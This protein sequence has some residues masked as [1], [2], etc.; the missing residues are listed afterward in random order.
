MLLE[1]LSQLKGRGRESL[2][3]NTSYGYDY[4]HA[5]CNPNKNSRSLIEIDRWNKLR[6]RLNLRATQMQVL[7][8]PLGPLL[9]P[10]ANHKACF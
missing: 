10:E 9:L 6:H 5:T 4:G 8:R 3:K 2:K 1:Y 7:K